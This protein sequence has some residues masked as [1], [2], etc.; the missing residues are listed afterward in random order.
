MYRL[1]NKLPDLPTFFLTVPSC[2]GTETVP[3]CRG[4]EYVSFDYALPEF[5]T[6]RA[7]APSEKSTWRKWVTTEDEGWTYN[8]LIMVILGLLVLRTDFRSSKVLAALYESTMIKGGDVT[9]HDGPVASPFWRDITLHFGAVAI[10]D[11]VTSGSQKINGPQEPFFP[12]QSYF[13]R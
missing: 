13:G 8:S 7:D 12:A 5:A 4:T 3:S 10:L 6:S 2:R 11:S 1:L 9:R